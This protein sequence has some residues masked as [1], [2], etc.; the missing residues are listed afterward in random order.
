MGRATTTISSTT[1][2]ARYARTRM[3]DA[4]HAATVTVRGATPEQLAACDNLAASFRGT[5][6]DAARPG[7][8]RVRQAPPSDGQPW[9]IAG[10]ADR[11]LVERR[12]ASLADA[13]RRALG[14][15]VAT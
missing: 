7:R 4:L 5:Q 11:E 8:Y 3:R 9:P 13:L 2:P 10:D 12:A 1:K 15:E 14:A 6:R